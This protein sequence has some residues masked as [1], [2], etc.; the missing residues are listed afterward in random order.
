MK[1]DLPEKSSI[2]KENENNKIKNMESSINESSLK[3][4]TNTN[5]EIKEELILSLNIDKK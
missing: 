5:N 3:I 4:N 1:I 2:N